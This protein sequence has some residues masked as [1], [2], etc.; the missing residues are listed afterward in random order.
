MGSKRIAFLPVAVLAMSLDQLG[1][2]YTMTTLEVGA[3][4]PLV[5]NVLALTHVPSMGAAFGFFREWAPLAQLIGFSI[6]ALCTSVLILAFYRGLPHGEQGSAAALGAMLGG[7]ASY[8]L[9]RFRYGSGLDFLHLGP[10]TS[11]AIPDLSFADI[12]IALGVM[13]LIVELLANEM[14]ARASERPRA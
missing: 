3:R 12:A 4:I 2:F 13:A 7:I 14:A 8:A 10:I 1:K 9:D 11:N 6:L 5:G